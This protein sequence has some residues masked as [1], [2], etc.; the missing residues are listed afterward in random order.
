MVNGTK[1]GGRNMRG[2]RTALL[3]LLLAVAF[4]A[5]IVT[6]VAAT[7]CDKAKAEQAQAEEK[8]EVKA[9]VEEEKGK[10]TLEMKEVDPKAEAS[11]AAATEK[12]E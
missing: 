6:Q 3:S 11:E 10:T 5:G 4:V 2:K 1:Q 12:P 9:K 7:D 8:V